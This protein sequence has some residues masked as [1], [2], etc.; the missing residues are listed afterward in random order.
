MT[1]ELIFDSADY[2]QLHDL[3]DST[4]EE[5]IEEIK[6]TG[7]EE[8]L[9]DDEAFKMSQVMDYKY[10]A[11]EYLETSYLYLKRIRELV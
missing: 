1:G 2:A 9:T 4:A 5:T 11:Q 10:K 3:I 8:E 6:P 7:D